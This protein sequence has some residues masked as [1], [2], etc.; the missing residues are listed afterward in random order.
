MFLCRLGSRRQI[1]H[2]LNTPRVAAYLSRI[3]R[4]ELA[5]VPHGDTVADVLV[6]LS[7][8][9]LGQL[10]TDL[11]RQLIVSRRLEKFRLLG[12]DYLVTLDGTGHV[13]CGHEPSPF[14]EG[15]LTRKLSNGETLYYRPVLE[16]K[17]VTRTGLA[18]SVE[19]EFLENPPRREGQSQ[20][21][22]KQDCELKGA[23]RLLPRLKEA[24]PELSV[25]LLGDGLYAGEPF[26]ALADRLRW[27]FIVV[28]ADGSLP[29]VQREFE[30]LVAVESK[31]KILHSTKKAHQVIRWVNDIAYG[32]RTLHVLECVDTPKDGSEPT[33][34]LWATNIP[35]TPE[36]ALSLANEGGRQRWRT[37]NEA[38]NVQK[39]GGFAM[40]HAYAKD[41]TAARNFYL[42]LQIAHLF[43]QLFEAH[44]GGKKDVTHECGSLR[45]LAHD[46]LEALRTDPLPSDEEAEAFLNTPIQV[47]LDVDSS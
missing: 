46:L 16:A 15:C 25:C 12:T 10:R 2:R 37:E 20:E 36:N 29:T 23:Y 18:L 42:L 47:R 27:H 41:P 32:Q 40:E 14:T 8:E 45:N 13:V 28:L 1:G 21:D 6:H 24:F 39:N 44:L 30:A 43:A 5:R 17:L 35:I 3:A 9:A 7:V 26:F 34:W 31:N 33:R 22:Y 19:T 11:V 38:F 4:Q